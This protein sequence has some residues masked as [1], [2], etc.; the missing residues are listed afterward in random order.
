MSA[1]TIKG[2]LRQVMEPVRGNSN[3][4]AWVKVPFVIE[5]E[6]TYP[7]K[8]YMQ[9][10]GNLANTILTWDLGALVEFEISIESK[11]FNER[12]YTTVTAIKGENHHAR[13]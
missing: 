9:A 1:L 5:T 11:E 10:W 12:Q 6:G 13:Y 2:R 8:V 3:G 7:A 4:K